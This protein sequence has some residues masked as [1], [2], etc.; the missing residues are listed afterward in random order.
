MNRFDPKR[1]RFLNLLILV[2]VTSLSGPLFAKQMMKKLNVLTPVTL[3]ASVDGSGEICAVTD[4]GGG[5]SAVVWLNAA[6]QIVASTGMAGSKTWSAPSLLLGDASPKGF[7]T[8]TLTGEVDSGWRLS[9]RKSGDA[10]AA[11]WM[12]KMWPTG[13]SLQKNEA[14]SPA[15]DS[16]S[17]G[18][19]ASVEIDGTRVVLR[20]GKRVIGVTPIF[21]S[22]GLVVSRAAGEGFEDVAFADEIPDTTIAGAAL[23]VVGSKVIGAYVVK[24]ASG[25]S[26]CRVVQM[27]AD[28][29][30]LSSSAWKEQPA[31]PQ[32]PGRAGPMTGAHGGVLI[33]A[34]GTDWPEPGKKMWH[35]TIYALVPGEKTW[36]PAGKLAGPRAYGAT[37]S[38][39]KGV[40]VIGGD[41]G[42]DPEELCQDVFLMAWNGTKVQITPLPA[43]PTPASNSM[44]VVLDDMI[45]F[46][47]GAVGS[48]RLSSSEFLRLDLA[49][50]ETGWQS[51]PTWPGVGRS[52]AVMAA[53]DGAIYLL[54]G[55]DTHMNA[56]GKP[57]SVYLSDGFRFVPID[58]AWEKLPDLPWSAIAAPSPAPVTTSPSRV[59]VLGGV[60]GRQ[61]G[62]LPPTTRVPEDVMYFDVA[63]HAWRLW[64]E[65][66]PASAVT[67]PAV[68]SGS[69]WHFVSGEIMGGVR[70]TE[71]WTW[72]ISEASP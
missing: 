34:G 58:N 53:L 21:P 71:V 8:L 29:R 26:V 38:T 12:S 4:L 45:Y 32:A 50:P 64:P 16:T 15:T 59:F 36:R 30:A 6:G 24:D 14:D 61:A 57:E 67:I 72:K 42:N 17:A 18:V 70:T 31:F 3:G 44:A 62:K 48:P 10:K 22:A 46:A 52:H 39:P 20:S 27:A 37:V 51:L 1:R 41:R 25:G 35:D 55:L 54:S 23:A 49:Q 11:V 13:W 68:G 7:S 28:A 43:L 63:E 40:V 19:F 2:A 65:R 56:E 47:G 9:A 60:D 69:E 66:W 5:Q 33:S